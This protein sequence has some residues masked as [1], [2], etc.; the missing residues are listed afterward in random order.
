MAGKKTPRDSELEL[1]QVKTSL[2]IFMESYN[3]SIP[4]SFPHTTIKILKKFQALHPMLFRGRDEWSIDRHRKRVMD[5]L[6]SHV[7]TS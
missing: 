1:N 3:K 6:P 2:L 5:W 7:S 4:E